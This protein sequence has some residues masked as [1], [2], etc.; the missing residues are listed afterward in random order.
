M[1][2]VGLRSAAVAIALAATVAWAAG[3]P[4]YEENGVSA[5]QL[6]NEIV[7]LAQAAQRQDVVALAMEC[8]GDHPGGQSPPDAAHY[9][10][11]EA[12]YAAARVGDWNAVINDLKHGD[13]G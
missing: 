10:L 12:A 13:G 8:L 11:V 6:L 3:W 4:D 9:D 7:V 5:Q 1:R 2:R